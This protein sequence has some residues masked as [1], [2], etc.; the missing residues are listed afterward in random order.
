VTSLIL[1]A[2]S[3]GLGTAVLIVTISGLLGGTLG[4]ADQIRIMMPFVPH[5][6]I[7]KPDPDSGGTVSVL[8]LTQVSSIYTPSAECA[9]WAFL[10]LALG[11]IGLGLGKSQGRLHW[12][13]AIGVG[14]PLMCL[15]LIVLVT[16]LLLMSGHTLWW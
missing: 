4:G 8:K 6:Y 14:I 2:A 11:L 13:S 3:V 16:S 1:G 15:L 12:L 10:A 7:D 5:V 9:I